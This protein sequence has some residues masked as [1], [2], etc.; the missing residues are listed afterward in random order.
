L[1]LL[2]AGVGLAA[3]WSPGATRGGGQQPPLRGSW[4]VDDLAG[5]PIWSESV[6]LDYLSD[7]GS[8][9][10]ALRLCIY[11][12]REAAW[13]WL[14]VF[15][16]PRILA[17]VDNHLPAPPVRHDATDAEV[18]YALAPAA[19]AIH[20]RF[21]RRA[22]NAGFHGVVH[23]RAALHESA[24]PPEGPGSLPLELEARFDAD[25]EAEAPSPGRREIFGQVRANLTLEGIGGRTWSG[26]GKWHEQHQERARWTV[27][28]SYLAV[29][30]TPP[31]EDDGTS[32]LA[33]VSPAGT[34]G[35]LRRA[36]A[37]RAVS[38]FDIEPPAEARH[39]QVTLAD[40]VT[41]EGTAER[42]RRFSVPIYSARREGSHVRVRLDDRHLLGTLNDWTARW[43]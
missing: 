16:G 10:L 22:S 7:D 15:D 31:A 24:D 27:P 40:G 28:F 36:G 43:E 1:L 41:L 37:A 9:G 20:A 11:P 30:Q 12:E 34:Y 26:S 6:A 4:S 29:Q 33:V 25:H 5:K 21:D 19:T 2:G 3:G 18:S 23:L 8:V 14:F 17:F 38:A 42:L 13:L 32:L 35:F 39:F